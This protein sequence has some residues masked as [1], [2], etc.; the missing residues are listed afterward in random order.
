MALNVARIR[1]DKYRTGIIIIV[2]VR[3]AT[4]NLEKYQKF[5][6]RPVIFPTKHFVHYTLKKVIFSTYNDNNNNNSM[7]NNSCESQTIF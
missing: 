4:V 1:S 6:K 3:T 5:W 7:V 2:P